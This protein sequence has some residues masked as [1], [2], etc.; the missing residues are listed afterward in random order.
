[1][2]SQ[3]HTVSLGK[4]DFDD[5]RFRLSFH[6]EYPLLKESIKKLGVI[7]PPILLH[8]PS[9]GYAIVSGYGRLSVS[10]GLRKSELDCQ[11]VCEGDFDD[12][13]GLFLVNLYENLTGRGLNL[14][15]QSIALNILREYFSDRKIVKVFLPMLGYNA[16]SVL[17]ERILSFQQLPLG[18]RIML[19][20][21]SLNPSIVSGLSAL[22][23][24]E[25]KGI[26]EIIAQ[27]RMTMSVQK[28]FVEGIIALAKRKKESVGSILEGEGVGS[29][30]HNKKLS[31]S[32]KAAEIRK[33]FKR[34][35]YPRFSEAEERF[36]SIVTE[37]GLAG[38]C[39]ISPPPSFEGK[40]YKFEI[41]A[42]TPDQLRQK[43]H[44]L[45]EK[46]DA[47]RDIFEL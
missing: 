23:R 22:S 11:V 28:E 4:I 31:P 9:G 26:L 43:L 36:R 25:Q 37:S 35:L 6:R 19:V 12:E 29:I 21:E 15:E 17:L 24:E 8:L 45:D 20:E 27:T 5:E 2:I 30:M 10:K 47:I 44:K 42:T 16:S 1:M 14:V 40:S 18:G 39:G 33:H 38:T 7:N 41:T 3:I 46:I 34:H 13:S 32:E